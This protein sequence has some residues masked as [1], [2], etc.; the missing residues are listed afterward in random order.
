VCS[1]SSGGGSFY[2]GEGWPRRM[3]QVIDD[4]V[5]TGAQL[6]GRGRCDVPCVTASTTG[7]MALKMV[8]EGVQ[9]TSSSSQYRGGGR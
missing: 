9:A 8:D 4:D 6:R 7:V 3:G 1:D 2:S 5:A